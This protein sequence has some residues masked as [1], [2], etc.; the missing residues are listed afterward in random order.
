MGIK[1]VS[2]RP[3]SPPI[4]SFFQMLF[5]ESHPLILIGTD[6]VTGKRCPESY[7]GQRITVDASMS[8]YQ[9]L[10]V[11]GRKGTQML[12]NEAG[13]L[14]RMFYRTI[15]LLEAGIKPVYVFDGRPPD[16]KKQELAK[17]F[18]KRED[19]FEEL[20][21]QNKEDI[22]KFSKRTV[23]VTQQHNEGC[24]K[25]LRLMG[26]PV[27]EAPSGAEAQ[28]AALCKAGKVY[29]FASEDVD[30][31][32]F[33]AP[34]FLRHSMDPSSRKVQ[35]MEFEISKI[36]EEMNLDMDQF[37]D[38]CILSGCDYCESIRAYMS[39]WFHRNILEDINKKRHQIPDNWPYKEARLLFK[40]PIVSTEEQ[41]K[42]KWTAPNEEGL[43]S[44]LMN[45][46]GFNI[47]RV[48]KHVYRA[49]E[50]IKAAKDES[51]QGRIESFF[52]PAKN[53]YTS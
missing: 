3:P 46:N 25:L 27:V 38:L 24:K 29:A 26:V 30:S 39:T 47:D 40:G 13:G 23:K 18:S 6:K 33:G 14:G 21:S 16:L 32:T 1:V 43:I 53:I 20:A 12:T 4:P 11:V 2:V 8:I 10:V 48:T 28:C 36:L 44:F 31:L 22:K 45:E 51:S 7:F 9:F 15:R 5:I 52:K 49:I 37:I 50:K 42:I 34:I 17:G 41:P 19:A 35:V